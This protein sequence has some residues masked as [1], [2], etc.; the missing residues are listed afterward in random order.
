MGQ[1]VGEDAQTVPRG[2]VMRLL[3]VA[4]VLLFPAT[5]LA[6]RVCAPQDYESA[7]A[8]DFDC[9]GP[10]ESDIVPDL[11]PPPAVA[12]AAGD[13]VEVQWDG[14]LVHRD[15]L[16]YM[17]LRLRATRRLRWLDARLSLERAQIEDEYRD[18]RAEAESTYCGERV[19]HYRDLATTA[20]ERVQRSNAWYRQFGFGLVVGLVISGVLVALAAYVVTAI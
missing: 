4:I 7:D 6:Q 3:I 8:P 5:A 1:R 2:H 12:V 17:G 16:I 20:N 11:R 18:E 19:Q 15:R 10:G 13:V 14:A 9:P